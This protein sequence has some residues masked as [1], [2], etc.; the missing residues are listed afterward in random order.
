LSA[1]T[2]S[3]RRQR[4]AEQARQ[5]PA[6]PCRTLAHLLDVE[7]LR[8]AYHQRRGDGAP[9][10]DGVTAAA[11]AANLEAN[12]ADWHERR[13]RGRDDAPPVTRA[14]VPKADGRQRASGMPACEAK[15]VQRAVAMVWG[16]LDAPDFDACSYG[17]RAGRRPPQA[18]PGLR[19]RCRREHSGWLID[20]EV[21]AGFA[22]LDHALWGEVLRPRVNEGAILRLIRKWLRAGGR[23]G[24]TR[25]SPARGSAQGGVVSPLLATIC[26]EHVLAEWCARAVQPRMTGRGC[27]R[28]FAADC[29]SGGER[30]ADARRIL[31]VLLQRFARFQRTIHPQKT[32]LVPFPPPRRPDEGE[33]GDGTFD[34]R[35]RTHSGAQSR[36]GYGVITRRTAKKRVRRAMRAVWP[37]CRTPRH[38]SMRAPYRALCQ[39][40]RGPDQ[41]DGMRG[42]DRKLEAFYRG[43]ER[44]WR[45]GWSRRGGPRPLRWETCAPLRAVLPLPTPRIVPSR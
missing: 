38:D 25:S 2:V 24:E 18:R 42:N 31:A 7:R 5:H 27:R 19:E 44:A 29:V 35:G 32:G 10:G 21:S 30:E 4:M 8:E 45:Y 26:L 1:P 20:A 37:W 22:R 6:M 34:C 17:F 41:Y 33:R 3:T 23:E 14:A 39:K 15:L 28:R 9:G 13:R 11:Y 40:L 16:T 12:L 43:V 36:R